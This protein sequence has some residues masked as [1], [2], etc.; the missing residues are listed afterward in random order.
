MPR[1]H[2]K[3]SRGSTMLVLCVLG[4]A[5]TRSGGF[6]KFCHQT[7]VIDYWW[8]RAVHPLIFYVK[9]RAEVALSVC[10]EYRLYAV[11]NFIAFW[12]LKCSNVFLL[13]QVN[14]RHLIFSLM[15]L[16]ACRFN[17][18]RRWTLRGCWGFTAMRISFGKMLAL[19]WAENVINAHLLVYREPSGSQNGGLW[20]IYS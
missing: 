8:L 6:L 16:W 15:V 9:F 1:A 5:F 18:F 3:I 17:S 7:F 13:F 12:S 20:L 14:L 2:F 11:C 19:L 4:P 10:S